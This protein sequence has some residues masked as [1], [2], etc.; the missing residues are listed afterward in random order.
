MK[1]QSLY[2][3]DASI[4]IFRSW[5]SMPDTI[6]NEQGESINALY[7]YLLF[8]AKF[9]TAIRAERFDSS[10]LYIAF[11][12]DESLQSCFRNKIY[13]AYKASRGLPD[14]NLAF[15]LKLCK[16]LTQTIGLPCFASK[17]Y[18][19]DDLIGSLASQHRHNVSR[20]VILTRDKDLGQLLK[21]NDV[22]WDFSEQIIWNR[23]AFQKKFEVS[24]EQFVD[25]LALVG[26]A[27]DD[28]PGIV[29]LGSKSAISLIKHFSNLDNIYASIKDIEFLNIRGA[30]R[31][32]RLLIEQKT[33]AYMSQALASIRCDV[34]LNKQIS[35]LEWSGVNLKK[36][37][38][39]LNRHGI[40]GRTHRAIMNAFADL[41]TVI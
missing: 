2:L 4:Y 18:E 12:F 28:I 5:F 40:K 11:A 13:H 39:A 16:S 17:R 19:A 23:D 35:D 41:E 34:T 37:A 36:L 6:T 22:L 27:V 3:V 25:Y 1:D 38:R 29:G 7:G 21:K 32:Q 9:L 20:C 14:E 26:D 33:Q 8:V 30:S 24:P 15:Q 10:E 31:I